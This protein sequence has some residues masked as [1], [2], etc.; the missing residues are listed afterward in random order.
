MRAWR[1]GADEG[2]RPVTAVVVA[3]G[4]LVSPFFVRWGAA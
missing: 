1:R 3:A 4:M 2:A